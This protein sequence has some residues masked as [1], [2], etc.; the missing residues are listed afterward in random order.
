MNKSNVYKDYFK[1][2]IRWS[3]CWANIVNEKGFKTFVNCFYPPQVL[4]TA[5]PKRNLCLP[6]LCELIYKI[7][8]DNRLYLLV[9]CAS[10]LK[11]GSTIKTILE[12]SYNTTDTFCEHYRWDEYELHTDEIFEEEFVLQTV[13]I[14]FE[15]YLQ[16]TYGKK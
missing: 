15:K 10:D 12:G 13:N 2:L 6:F 1:N 9:R 8:Q 4:I 16:I 14:V 11:C 3:E 5:Y 7:D